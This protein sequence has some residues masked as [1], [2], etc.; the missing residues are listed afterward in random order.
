[1][2]MCDVIIKLKFDIV[3][4]NFYFEIEKSMNKVLM[5]MFCNFKNI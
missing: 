1:M 4:M 5:L 2:N 3:W